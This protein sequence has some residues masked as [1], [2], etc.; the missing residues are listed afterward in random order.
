MNKRIEIFNREQAIR[1]NYASKSDREI[2]IDLHVKLNRM[3]EK[4][5]SFE[6]SAIRN[7]TEQVIGAINGVNEELSSI[8]EQV[9]TLDN[10]LDYVSNHLGDLIADMKESINENIADYS[11]SLTQTDVED[12]MRNAMN[13]YN[14]YMLESS[15]SE[16][17]KNG[18]DSM[19]DEIVSQTMDS[20][21]GAVDRAIQNVASRE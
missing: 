16:A 11:N 1:E 20:I 18:L 17:I 7:N 6:I 10:N 8:T 4:L 19:S 14:S 21:E 5:D 2:S 15:I 12:A 3:M 9:D 13:S